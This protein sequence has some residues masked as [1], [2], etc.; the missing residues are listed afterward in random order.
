LLRLEKKAEGWEEMEV[1]SV[2]GSSS[3]LLLTLTLD[4]P[5]LSVDTF[6]STLFSYV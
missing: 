5:I 1:E 4:P 3:L 6:S 2:V